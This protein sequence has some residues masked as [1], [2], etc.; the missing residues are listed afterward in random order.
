LLLLLFGA[1][2]SD[3]GRGGRGR[4]GRGRRRYYDY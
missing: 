2:D 4:G 3:E 1:F